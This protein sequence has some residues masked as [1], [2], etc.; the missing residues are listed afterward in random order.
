VIA[1]TAPEIARDPDDRVAHAIRHGA[2]TLSHASDPFVVTYLLIHGMLKLAIAINLLRGIVWIFPLATV[3]LTGFIVFMS[4]RLTTHYSGWL[5]GFVLF[6][7]MTLA[8]VLNEWRTY[9]AR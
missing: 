6:D 8:L 3:I 7:A 5:L 1:L 9:R 4:C 2:A